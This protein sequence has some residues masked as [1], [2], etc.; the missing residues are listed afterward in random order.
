M[1]RNNEDPIVIAPI[2]LVNIGYDLSALLL[3]YIYMPRH[4]SKQRE[5]R[6]NFAKTQ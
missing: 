2:S 5:K 4:I 6:E 1:I 3:R